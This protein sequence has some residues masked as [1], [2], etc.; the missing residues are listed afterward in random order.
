M[1]QKGKVKNVPQEIPPNVMGENAV[2]MTHKVQTAE[3]WK[4]EMAAK[5]KKG[6][7]KGGES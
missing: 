3:G 7:K 6:P 4:R 5:K 1:I 2:R